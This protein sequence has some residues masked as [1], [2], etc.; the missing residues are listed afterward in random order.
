ML[1]QMHA[2]QLL[3]TCYPIFVK[4]SQ[5]QDFQEIEP[6]KHANKSTAFQ[7]KLQLL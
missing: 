3:S 4:V 5:V 1:L 2:H 6:E 7:S